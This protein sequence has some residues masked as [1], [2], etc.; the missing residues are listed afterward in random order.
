M[1][2]Q[3]YVMNR[4]T[5]VRPGEDPDQY[6]HQTTKA[7]NRDNSKESLRVSHVTKLA[8]PLPRFR[9]TRTASPAEGPTGLADPP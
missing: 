7:T 6:R 1:T 5:S 3:S 9:H 8:V 4:P 2:E